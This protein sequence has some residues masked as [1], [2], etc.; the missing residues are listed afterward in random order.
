[1]DE[2]KIIRELRSLGFEELE[3]L[4]DK[5]SSFDS[6][7]EIL[8]QA[9]LIIFSSSSINH[10]KRLAL[11]T[12]INKVSLDYDIAFCIAH[13]LTLSIK[14]SKELGIHKNL[15]KDSHKVIKLWKDI[16]D[17]PLA[18]NGLI[19]AYIDLGLI[20]S[21][22]N[23]NSLAIKYLNK[24]ESLLSEC[25]DDYYPFI[26]LYVAYA[27]V[28]GRLKKNK[29]VDECYKK[30]V[31]IAKSKKDSLTLI[32]IFNNT[33]SEFIKNKKYEDAKKRCLEALR[34]SDQN[35]ENI[36]KPHIHNTL[37]VAY[38]ETGSYKRS[39]LYFKKSLDG[40]KIMNTIN[41]VPEVLYNIGQVFYSDNKYSEALIFLKD[42]LEKSNVIKKY[43]LSIKIAKKIS[44]IYKHN[45][46]QDLYLKSIKILNNILE[47]QIKSK[48]RIFSD[49]NVS[50][51]KHLS[52]E[53]DLSL[54]MHKDLHLKMNIESNKR[55]LATE[56]L[57]SVSEKDFLN[58]IIKLL[59][60]GEFESKKIAKLC[61]RRIKHTKDW[62]LF[63]KLFN[64]IHPKFNQYIISK[65][66]SITESELRVCNLVKMGFSTLEVA[67]ILS[68]TKRGVEQHRYRIRKKINIESDLTIFLLSI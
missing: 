36:Y 31:N 37:G 9:N 25:S 61:K 65:C 15:I 64:D 39:E 49:T 12:S 55:K 13:S 50:A 52:D 16:L 42:A 56:T 30:V 51:L 17:Q 4:I 46:N 54:R 32:P 47:K 11:L 67:D 40:F 33:A 48:E 28:Y 27:V 57:I 6:V 68:I 34:I 3:L 8:Y 14:V 24:A 20:F 43:S 21:D 10:K 66:P 29:K 5:V 53:F 62:D 44:E 18:I 7:R 59:S 35:K 26:K 2:N 1:V 19:F 38:L 45:K 41:M 58:N 22:F 23:L 63:L 60:D